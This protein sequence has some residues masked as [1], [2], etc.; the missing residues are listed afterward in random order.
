MY[1][2][3]SEVQTDRQPLGQLMVY[4]IYP[5]IVPVMLIVSIL[6]SVGFFLRHLNDIYIKKDIRE[7]L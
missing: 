5:I 4:N 1:M 2:Y 3:T 6:M 7:N